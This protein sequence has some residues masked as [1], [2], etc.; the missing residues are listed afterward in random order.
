M[1][2]KELSNAVGVSGDEAEVRKIVIDAISEHVTDLQVDSMGNVTAIQ[3]GTQYPDYTIMIA[4]HMDEITETSEVQIYEQI[5]VDVEG[6]P[7]IRALDA[8][9]VE[10]DNRLLPRGW[11]ATHEQIERIEPIGV[12]GDENFEAGGDSVSYRFPFEGNSV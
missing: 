4:A 6:H 10:K 12:D 9:A 3:Q 7:T 8:N 11:S 1:L 2:L 5:L